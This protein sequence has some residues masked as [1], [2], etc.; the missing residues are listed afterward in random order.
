MKIFNTYKI[1]IAITDMR[2]LATTVVYCYKCKT[3]FNISDFNNYG[4][5]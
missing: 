5:G 3:S 2:D 4:E 1:N